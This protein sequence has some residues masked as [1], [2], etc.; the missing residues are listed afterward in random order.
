MPVGLTGSSAGINYVLNVGGVYSGITLPGT[1]GALS[2][3]PA[4]GTRRLYYFRCQYHHRM[5]CSYAGRRYRDGKSIACAI[6]GYRRRHYCS[7]SA[8]PHVVVASSDPGVHY[9]LYN[10]A[11]LVGTYTTGTGT[12]VD[13]GMLPTSGIYSVLAVNPATTC[14]AAMLDSVTVTRVSAVVPSVTIASGA[15]ASAICSGTAVTFSA[16]PANGGATPAYQ[17]SVNGVHMGT[18]STAYTYHPANGD[19]V[20]VTLISSSACATGPATSVT[21]YHHGYPKRYSCRYYRHHT[22]QRMPGSYSVFLCA[23]CK[24]WP[25]TYL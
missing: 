1:G 12:P 21:G 24:R 18:D 9:M 16:T 5:F 15:G 19:V 6:C 7:D 4:T 8:A 14:S 3:G 10:G 17:W 2:F 20:T 22:R 25:Y 23:A 11:T 13:F